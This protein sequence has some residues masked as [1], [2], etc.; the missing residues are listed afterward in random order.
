MS[1][2]HAHS[3]HLPSTLT[4]T[5]LRT[6]PSELLATHIYVPPSEVR[7]FAIVRVPLDNSCM[8]SVVAV[9]SG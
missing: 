4:A 3:H 2:N 1:A 5:V 7:T 6:V 9:S 8:P